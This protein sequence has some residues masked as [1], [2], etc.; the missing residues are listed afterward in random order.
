MWQCALAVVLGLIASQIC[1][2]QLQGGSALF[3]AYLAMSAVYWIVLRPS[4]FAA[5][6]LPLAVLLIQIAVIQG[7]LYLGVLAGGYLDG[8]L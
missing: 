4:V 6:L 3:A 7:L 2:A 8:Y 1:L 5:L